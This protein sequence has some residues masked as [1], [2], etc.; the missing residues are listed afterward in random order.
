MAPRREDATAKHEKLFLRLH[1]CGI[2][3]PA[4]QITRQGFGLGASFDRRPGHRGVGLG[5]PFAPLLIGPVEKDKNLSHRLVGFSRNF[6][7]NVQLC[8]QVDQRIVPLHRDLV[9]VSKLKDSLR[10][11][12]GAGGDHTWRTI[13]FEV[14]ERD[15]LQALLRL[16]RRLELIHTGALPDENQKRPALK[17]WLGNI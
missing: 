7:A 12:P 11:L 2:F 9:L 14:L 6:E 3:G 17:D 5:L 4:V 15:G 13:T 8:E 16:R 1:F 10:E